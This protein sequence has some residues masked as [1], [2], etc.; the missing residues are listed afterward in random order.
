MNGPRLRVRSDVLVLLFVGAQLR[1]F[2]FPLQ[3]TGFVRQSF[4]RKTLVSDQMVQY[5]NSAAERIAFLTGE[6]L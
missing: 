2:S 4:F 6:G 1:L 3:A 5:E